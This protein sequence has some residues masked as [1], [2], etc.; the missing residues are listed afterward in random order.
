MVCLV[1]H[2]LARNGSASEESCPDGRI[3]SM[4]SGACL[5]IND[6]RERFS[7]DQYSSAVQNIPNLK[8]LRRAKISQ[9]R[10]QEEGMPVPGGLGAGITFKA[11]SLQVLEHAELQTTMFVYPDGLNPSSELEWLFTSAT[12]RTEKTVEVVGV[13]SGFDGAQLGI[14]DWS[15]SESYPCIN[16]KTEAGWIFTRPFYYYSCNMTEIEDS[17]GHIR[18]AM[19]YRNKSILVDQENP[20][21]WRND[22]YLWNVCNEEW[23][24]IYSHVFQADQKD[25]S[26]DNSCGWW[27]PIIETFGTQQPL[28]SEVGFEDTMLLHDGTWSYL[29]PEDTLFVPP[30]Y[31]WELMHL[32]PN[33]GFGVGNST[34]QASLAPAYPQAANTMAAAY[35]QSSL[36]GSGVFNTLTLLFMPITMVAAMRFLR[37]RM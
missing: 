6:V 19:T 1:L 22:V 2:L 17:G 8:E 32:T 15:C 34:T 20:P 31:P 21:L 18:T 16:G 7:E 23:D 3:L 28:I 36:I 37:R 10:L 30:S 24:L 14:F 13:Y 12:N 33:S 29:T 11:G 26:I 5:P 27:G 25:C 4:Y 35:G 9:R